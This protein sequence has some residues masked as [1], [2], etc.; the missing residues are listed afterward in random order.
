VGVASGW[1]SRSGPA[2]LG[3]AKT[4]TRSRREKLPT[5][6][7]LSPEDQ[8]AEYEAA[9][10]QSARQITALEERVRDLASYQNEAIAARESIDKLTADLAAANARAD[11]AD[12]DAAAANTAAK[13]AS[14]QAEA[15]SAQA[16]AA[17]QLVDALA[18]LTK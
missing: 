3:W 7:K 17:A 1:A 16:E 6:T 15:S 18:K 9:L 8:A 4:T 10:D 11:K 13:A 12:R 2:T 14:T 5:K